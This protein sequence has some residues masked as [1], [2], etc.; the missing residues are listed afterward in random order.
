MVSPLLIFLSCDLVTEM[1]NENSYTGK[2][3]LHT[4]G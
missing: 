3:N 2:N 4:G 1:T